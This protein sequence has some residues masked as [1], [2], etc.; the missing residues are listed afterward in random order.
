[1]E[2]TPREAEWE[3][4]KLSSREYQQRP[5]VSQPASPLPSPRRALSLI[6]TLLPAMREPEWLVGRLVRVFK[7]SPPSFIRLGGTK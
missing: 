5:A 4:E 1:M 7:T 2:K 6:P 3:C